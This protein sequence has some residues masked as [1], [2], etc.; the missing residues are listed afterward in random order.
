MLSLF[1]YLFLIYCSFML[2]CHVPVSGKALLGAAA[3]SGELQLYGMSL[4]QVRSEEKSQTVM[5][6]VISFDVFFF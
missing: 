1:V 5:V 3:A 2:R 4:N 6:L